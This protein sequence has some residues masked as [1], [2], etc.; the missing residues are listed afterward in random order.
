[1]LSLL[2]RYEP[3]AIALKLVARLD[4]LEVLKANT[5]FVAGFNALNVVLRAPE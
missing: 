3:P 4:V 2:A 1:M 5:A